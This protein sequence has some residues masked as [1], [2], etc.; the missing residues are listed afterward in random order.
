MPAHRFSAAIASAGST[1]GKLQRQTLV[2][3]QD[4]H[5]RRI[6]IHLPGL[7]LVMACHLDQSSNA[8]GVKWRRYDPA[9]GRLSDLLKYFNPKVPGPSGQVLQ[10]M[11]GQRVRFRQ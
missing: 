7:P 9:Q 11:Q 10:R 3:G 4:I 6:K 1:A 2:L 8:R 5:K